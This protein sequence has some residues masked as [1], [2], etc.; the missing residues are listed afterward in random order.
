MASVHR[1]GSKWFVRWREQ[2]GVDSEGTPITRNK[3]RTCPTK[4]SADQVKRE[5][6]EASAL[7]RIWR[8]PA[9]REVTDLREGY[10]LYLEHLVRLQR[11]PS[12]FR[13][14]GTAVTV[15]Y[16]VLGV[17]KGVPAPATL[18]SR[19]ALRAVWQRFIDERKV[20][21]TTA[22]SRVKQVER[23]WAWM[24][25]E[26]LA[27]VPFPRTLS[28]LPTWSAV[29]APRPTWAECDV[30][31]RRMAD[32]EGGWGPTAR[33]AWISRCTG[34]RISTCIALKWAD[35][36]LERALLHVRPNDPG[37]KTKREA[38]GWSTPIPSPLLDVLK[39]WDR[40][41]ESVSG[42]EHAWSPDLIED[43]RRVRAYRVAL[44][45][46]EAATAAEEVRRD[47]WAPPGRR[48]RR[49][50]HAFRA[51]WKASL[52][53]AGVTKEVRQALIGGARGTDH[54]YV[55]AWSLPLRDAVKHI[56]EMQGQVVLT[57]KERA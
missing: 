6:E 33:S 21:P 43:R 32:E 50:L 23:W 12:T 35:V 11:S 16:E 17:R 46:W 2:V 9:E 45:A 44:R 54:S 10:Q 29:E 41:G 19:E 18:L 31:I 3:Q 42:W 24:H 25:G 27:G 34:L 26:E 1:K 5:V 38:Q 39:G 4:R 7:G 49:P 15:L 55:D 13:A 22:S 28:D 40:R 48:G 30:V 20:L 47:V 52:A 53:R 14:V 8:P 57:F 36:D 51:C 37:S 56:P